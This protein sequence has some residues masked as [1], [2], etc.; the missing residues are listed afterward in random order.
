MYTADQLQAEAD[1]LLEIQRE[2]K[3]FVTVREVQE[4]LGLSSTSH[5]LH[6]IKAMIRAGLI[7]KVR[8]HYHVKE[9]THP[10]ETN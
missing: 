4:V 6:R 3:L 7:V 2:K 10:T 8:N 9:P 1:R 5:A